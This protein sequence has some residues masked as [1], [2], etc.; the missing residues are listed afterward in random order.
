MITSQIDQTSNA[1]SINIVRAR[2]SRLLKSGGGR[3]FRAALG[4]FCVVSLAACQPDPLDIAKKA[5]EGGDPVAAAQ[6]Y[7]QYASPERPDLQLAL[8]QALAQGGQLQEAAAVYASL[9]EELKGL[10]GQRVELLAQAYRGET[11]EA[12]AGLTSLIKTTSTDPTLHAASGE[13]LGLM[14]DLTTSQQSFQA[15]LALAPQLPSAHVG[16]GDIAFA[17]GDLPEAQRLYDLGIQLGGKGKDGVQARTRLA[18]LK[19][20]LGEEV[21]ARELLREARELMPNHPATNAE[22][23]KFMVRS[24]FFT[25][26]LP[27]LKEAQGSLGEDPDLMAYIGYVFKER[28]RV[29]FTMRARVKDLQGAQMWFERVLKVDPK[30]YDVLNDLGQVRAR[31][32]DVEGA[33]EAYVR[34]YEASPKRLDALMNLG[35]LYVEQ[36]QVSRARGVFDRGL[37]LDPSNVILQINLGVLALREGDVTAAS[38]YFD[39]GEETCLALPGEHPCRPELYYNRSRVAGRL[40]NVEAS[41]DYFLKAW[42][43]GYRDIGRIMA[44]PDIEATRGDIRVANQLDAFH[45]RISN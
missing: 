21:E 5:M 3:L 36:G 39:K 38:A 40:G 45:M 11:A 9:S 6:I 34:A 4:L 19:M 31:L 7:Q 16:L 14:G 12:L 25:E 26:A 23:G 37:A 29:Q 41:V 15:A 32:G 44:E 28:A 43:A 20:A 10:E 35:R 27:L 42:G 30:R 17:K 8:A 33:E 18:R 13:V 24:G 1:S 22:V 2:A